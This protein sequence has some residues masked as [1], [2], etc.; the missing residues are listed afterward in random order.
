[1]AKEIERKFLI[2]GDYKKY[3]VKSTKITQGYLSRL[4]RKKNTKIN[5]TTR[6]RTRDKKIMKTTITAVTAIRVPERTAKE[7]RRIITER[8]T[9]FVKKESASEVLQ[10]YLF[11]PLSEILYPCHHP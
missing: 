10:F 6:L 4:L 7:I 5:S 8:V 3:V 9:D 11:L 2:K 1:M